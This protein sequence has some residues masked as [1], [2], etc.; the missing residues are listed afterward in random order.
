MQSILGN[1]YLLILAKH[2]CLE[3]KLVK[4]NMHHYYNKILQHYAAGYSSQT[5][6]M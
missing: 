4:R 3:M 5:N 1:A 6:K 2:L